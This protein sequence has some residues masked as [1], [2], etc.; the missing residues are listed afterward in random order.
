M[1]EKHLHPRI[2]SVKF[3]V[4]TFILQF[5]FWMLNS[6]LQTFVWTLFSVIFVKVNANLESL[7][8]F[9]I[10]ES[11]RYMYSGPK[12]RLWTSFPWPNNVCHF[13]LR[14]NDI[15]TR[16]TEFR[17]RSPL[18]IANI[19]LVFRERGPGLFDGIQTEFKLI[20]M[21]IEAA[22]VARPRFRRVLGKLNCTAENCLGSEAREIL[23]GKQ[24]GGTNFQFNCSSEWHTAREQTGL[25]C[26]CARQ[27][28]YRH[29]SVNCL[30]YLARI[31][32]VNDYEMQ[33]ANQLQR[34]LTVCA[35]QISS[36]FAKC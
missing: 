14:Q 36:L 7:Y 4:D 34:H 12:L 2:F 16:P 5:V 29:S 6:L 32:F 22:I 10:R 20:I 27:I 9:Y 3:D 11:A 8:Y 13:Y 21:K 30:R 18:Y 35:K 19:P 25:D 28:Y 15:A 24:I 33:W 26:F 1:G 17:H 23:H 31:T